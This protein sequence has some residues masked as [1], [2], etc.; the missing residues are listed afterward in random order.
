MVAELAHFHFFR[1]FRLRTTWSAMV[2][3]LK[4]RM[5]EKGLGLRTAQSAMVAEPVQGLLPSG[6]LFE[7]HPICHGY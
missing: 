4:A 6:V 7:N 5:L 1:I 3:E 2:T